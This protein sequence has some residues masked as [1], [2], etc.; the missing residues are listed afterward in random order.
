AVRVVAD[1]LQGA[2]I[3]FAGRTPSPNPGVKSAS[4]R[5]QEGAPARLGLERRQAVDRR[6]VL[7]ADVVAQAV[8]ALALE[9]QL[10]LRALADVVHQRHAV[11]ARVGDP[12][13]VDADHA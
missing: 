4:C 5:P 10:A 1:A 6:A 9:P 3:V 11:T 12:I 13:D 8:R 2:S 7:L